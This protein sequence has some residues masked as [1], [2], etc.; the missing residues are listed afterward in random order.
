MTEK[1]EGKPKR[2]SVKKQAVKAGGGSRTRR[3]RRAKDTKK[4]GDIRLREKKKGHLHHRK[5]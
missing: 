5:K 1:T 3:K 2:L 4:N